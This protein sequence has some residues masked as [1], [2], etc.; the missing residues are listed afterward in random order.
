MGSPV[1]STPKLYRTHGGKR[2]NTRFMTTAQPEKKTRR[3]KLEAFVQ[4]NPGDA[5]GR[6]GLAVEC[7]NEGDNDAAISH[8]EKLLADHPTYVTGYFQFGQ[9]LARISQ[10]D[11]ARATLAAGIAAASRTGD[12]HAAEEMQAALAQL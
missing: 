2:Y 10:I 12:S 8:F 3:Q 7:G 11:R 9:F 1:Q 4:A 6:Y 5:F